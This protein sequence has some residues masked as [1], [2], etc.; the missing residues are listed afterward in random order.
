MKKLLFCLSV[1]FISYSGFAQSDALQ[2]AVTKLD[3]AQTVKD[4]EQLEKTFTGIK[5]PA[6]WLPAY[7]AALCNAKIGFLLQDDGDKI[8][9]YSI[10]G[11]EQAKKA[12]SL[13]DSAQQRKEVAEVYTVLSMVYRTKVFINP[14]TYGRK[15][16]TLSE[17][18]LKQARALDAQ[19]PRALFVAAWVKYYTP[20]MWGGDKGQAKQL[21]T[22]SLQYLVNPGT[23][24]TPHW[25]RP[26]DQ[27]LLSKI[28]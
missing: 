18:A 23:D 12:L 10:R 25:G 3:Q 2:Q 21:A 8:E 9:P 11:E 17:Q 24:V 6:A 15:Y 14:M 20:K 16:G 4:Y 5:A 7:Y 13:L 1:V 22:E 28:K 27:A 26:E 19:N